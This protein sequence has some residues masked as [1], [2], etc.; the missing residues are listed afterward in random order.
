MN[1]TDNTLPLLSS[2]GSH[3]H[4]GHH[5]RPRRLSV[6]NPESQ[7]TTEP[8]TV[9]MHEPSSGPA[10]SALSHLAPITDESI[11]NSELELL[12]RLTADTF[13][14]AESLQPL[15][16]S[17]TFPQISPSQPLF[18]RLN[19]RRRVFLNRLSVPRS[20]KSSVGAASGPTFTKIYSQ[21]TLPVRIYIP[22]PSTSL[23]GPLPLY[24]HIVPTSFL[25]GSKGKAAAR[26]ADR[27][28]ELLAY[29]HGICVAAVTFRDPPRWLFPTQVYDVVTILQDILAGTALPIDR[30]K[31]AIGGFGA[32]ASVALAVVQTDEMKGLIKGVLA[33]CPL[34]DWAIPTVDKVANI[35]VESRTIAI[36][37]GER[38]PSNSSKRQGN[39]ENKHQRKLRRKISRKHELF[40][41]AY[42]PP[43]QDLTDPKLS[44]AYAPRSTLPRHIFIVGAQCDVLCAE[45][46]KMALRLAAEERTSRV[47]SDEEWMSGSIRW[48][49]VLGCG[50]EFAFEASK[51]EREVE[52][53]EVTNDLFNRVA[54]WLRA[55]VWA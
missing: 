3:S 24:V 15:H 39:N 43:G 33:I 34:V 30:R 25:G 17:Y 18:N 23:P 32:G 29:Q 42:V 5:T 35:Q 16:Q 38:M 8:E 21:P 54:D 45:A 47:G 13:P 44:P 7:L 14:L 27:F 40:S 48:E 22:P 31:V 12:N 20:V 11:P 37:S 36:T 6:R 10:E 53:Q 49:L 28:A 1:A 46:E 51:D 26:A 41:Y 2:E 9:H 50:H 52:R 55:R 4:G 19:F